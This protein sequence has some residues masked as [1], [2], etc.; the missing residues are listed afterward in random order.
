MAIFFRRGVERLSIVDWQVWSIAAIP[1]NLTNLLNNIDLAS[2]TIF[3]MPDIP[4]DA[5]I[6][7]GPDQTDWY[8]IL[9]NVSRT[10]SVSGNDMLM[11]VTANNITLSN[12]VAN[13]TISGVV[14]A[15]YNGDD[16]N[17]TPLLFIMNQGTGLPYVTSAGVGVQIRFDS[18]PNG[19]IT[20]RGTNAT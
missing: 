5:R 20:Y 2:D 9:Q 4:T 8:V 13:Q 12:P 1:V 15:I 14:V 10:T 17:N 18:S 3:N 11:R 6:L 16:F 19:I 7:F